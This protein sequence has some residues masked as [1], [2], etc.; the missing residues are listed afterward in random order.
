MRRNTHYLGKCHL[1]SVLVE[2][3]PSGKSDPLDR[4]V[5]L[6]MTLSDQVDRSIF[7]RKVH[8]DSLDHYYCSTYQ[9]YILYTLKHSRVS[10]LVSNSLVDTQTGEVIPMG[11]SVLLH[12]PLGGCWWI[13]L[14]SNIQGHTVLPYH[15]ARL[16]HNTFQV[17]MLSCYAKLLDKSDRVC[18]VSH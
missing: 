6:E 10:F 13:L 15:P 9:L 5:S 16:D 17:Y 8:L 7:Y 12:I 3:I 2:V 18:N 4:D 1:D 11:N 14:D